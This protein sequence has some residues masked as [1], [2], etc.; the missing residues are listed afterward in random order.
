MFD[1]K[2]QKQGIRRNDYL[3]VL[4][5]SLIVDNSISFFVVATL[6]TFVELAYLYIKANKLRVSSWLASRQGLPDFRMIVLLNRVRQYLL[7]GC[8]MCGMHDYDELGISNYSKP[9]SP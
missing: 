6:F 3:V 4:L 5:S 2:C 8:T 1:C 9:I 7:R